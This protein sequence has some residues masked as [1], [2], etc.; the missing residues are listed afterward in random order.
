MKN[1]EFVLN[2]QPPPA[3]LLSVNPPTQFDKKCTWCFELFKNQLKRNL[4]PLGA[5][6]EVLNEKIKIFRPF[7]LSLSLASLRVVS[8]VACC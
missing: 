3:D 6:Q 4:R 2:E 7:S 5:F 8:Q 1:F